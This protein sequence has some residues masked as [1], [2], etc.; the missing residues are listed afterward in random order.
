MRF[1]DKNNASQLSNHETKD[2]SRLGSSRSPKD[3]SIVHTWECVTS[4]L[5]K[6][7]DEKQS[8]CLGRIAML[9]D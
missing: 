6:A 1:E 8:V 9:I 7:A 4:K 2:S 3:H 5:P